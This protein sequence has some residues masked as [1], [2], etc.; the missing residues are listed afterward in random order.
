MKVRSSKVH[1]LIEEKGPSIRR[2]AWRG[3][4]LLFK[5]FDGGLCRVLGF[6]EEEGG[7]RYREI[8][9]KLQKNCRAFLFPYVSRR[10]SDA[11]ISFWEA[12]D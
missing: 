9:K 8:E 7:N 10:V 3:Q 12:K 2:V 1:G 11:N 5:D 6:V 4:E